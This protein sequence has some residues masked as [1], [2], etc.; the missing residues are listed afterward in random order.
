MC[1][2]VGKEVVD[3]HAD[4]GE[5]ENDQAPDQLV[6]GRAVG[7]DDLNYAQTGQRNQAIAL[8]STDG[9]ARVQRCGRRTP[10]NDIENQDDEAHDTT[11]SGTLPRGRLGGDG[12]GLGHQGEGALEER[13]ESE[14]E[15]FEGC[16]MKKDRKM[17]CVCV[18]GMLE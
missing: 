18:Y 1:G 10:R 2:A 9:L 6:H 8:H 15:H 5:Q 12:G 16:W 4:D 13:G 7:L 3:D 14:L 17:L 11:P